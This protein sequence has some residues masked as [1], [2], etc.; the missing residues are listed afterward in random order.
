[1]TNG[2]KYL[3]HI[4]KATSLVCKPLYIMLPSAARGDNAPLYDPNAHR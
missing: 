3:D 1:M 2:W 4:H